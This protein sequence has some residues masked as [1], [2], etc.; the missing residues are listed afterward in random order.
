MCAVRYQDVSELRSEL[1]RV[2]TQM[3]SSRR[4]WPQEVCLSKAVQ[5]KVTVRPPRTEWLPGAREGA[6]Q[7]VSGQQ[8][9]TAAGHVGLRWF[10]GEGNEEG[11]GG[12]NQASVP[13]TGAGSE[14]SNEQVETA[15][16]DS[17]AIGDTN[18]E[19]TE[20]KA[21]LEAAELYDPINSPT[22]VQ[23]IPIPASFLKY[24][25]LVLAASPTENS[26][27]FLSLKAQPESPPQP[28]LL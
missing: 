16:L 20:T 25:P 9:N 24:L 18:T 1:N 27:P 12:L 3:C 7:G 14:E 22:C 5:G 2:Q 4:W 21:T 11:I 8:N 10:C 19:A 15:G 23:P 6:F 28:P 26:L 13:G 17:C